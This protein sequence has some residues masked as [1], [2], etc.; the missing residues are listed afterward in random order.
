MCFKPLYR[1]ARRG[2]VVRVKPLTHGFCPPQ[3]T[4][5]RLPA[6]VPWR[7]IITA[8]TPSGIRSSP[9]LA[10]RWGLSHVLAYMHHVA[11]PNKQRRGLLDLLILRQPHIILKQ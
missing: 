2:I 4:L 5:D 3:C 8:A 10:P 6:I 7:I 9:T 11:L 1:A